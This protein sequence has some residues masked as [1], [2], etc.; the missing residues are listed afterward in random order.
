MESQLLTVCL[1]LNLLSEQNLAEGSRLRL[2]VLT[3]RLRF[4]P[5]HASSLPHAQA[6]H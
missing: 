4:F 6:P 1:S 3:D 2:R 5:D